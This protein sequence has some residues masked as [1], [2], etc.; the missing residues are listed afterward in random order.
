[1]QTKTTERYYLLSVRM[2]I[3]KTLQTIDPGEGGE[4]SESY[5][6]VNEEVNCC[7]YYEKQYGGSLKKQKESP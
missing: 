1:M 6:I 3:V 5:Y 7:S 4:K 2:A